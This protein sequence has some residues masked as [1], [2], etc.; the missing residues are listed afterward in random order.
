M[1]AAS[2]TAISAYVFSLAQTRSKKDLNEFMKEFVDKFHPD[3]D[4]SFMEYFLELSK[5]ENEGEFMI[6]HEKLS[7]YGIMTSSR[8]NDVRDRV[9]A[10]GLQEDADYLLRSTPQ[11][12]SGG[13]PIITFWFTPEAFKTLLISARR[14]AKHKID[15]HRYRKYY[16]LL[17]KVVSYY[18]AYQ[19]QLKEEVLKIKDDKI[20]KLQTT[21]ESQTKKIDLQ[22]AEIAKLLGYAKDTKST[23]DETKATLEDVQ[24]D[25]YETK[26][27][28]EIAKSYL[29]EKS[30][31]STMNPK[32][33]NKHH[34]FAATMVS[35]NETKVVKFI[36]GQKAYVDSKIRDRVKLDQHDIIL[37]PFYNANGVD[38]RHNVQEE[39]K[40]RRAAVIK[41]ANAASVKRDKEANERLRRDIRAYNRSNPEAPRIYK[42]E[43]QNSRRA[44][45]S[46]IAVSFKK[47]S[48]IYRPNAYMSFDDVLQIIIDVNGTTQTSPLTE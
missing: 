8:S 25:L 31:T 45:P 21:V 4:L 38:L 7:E 6:P 10:L 41:A 9:Q 36:S 29:A 37:Q 20:D 33:E 24:D 30:F 28:V 3:T 1:I 16:L 17:E 5:E 48:F 11:N 44:R 47:L 27:T 23:L 40:K 39:F 18:M 43:K 34:F 32:D 19:L 13:R 46:D 35:I 42:N 2:K 12:P 22:S 15:V 26:E 14:Q